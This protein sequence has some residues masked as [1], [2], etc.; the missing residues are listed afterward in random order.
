MSVCDLDQWIRETA[1]EPAP[2]EPIPLMLPARPRRALPR[3]AGDRRTRV[4]R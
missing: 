2:S 3:R 1:A 4:T